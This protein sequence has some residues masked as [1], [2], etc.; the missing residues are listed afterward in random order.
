[1]VRDLANARVESLKILG[2]KQL[3]AEIKRKAEEETTRIEEACLKV[4]QEA[5]RKA[6]EARRKL[7][8]EEKLRQRSNPKGKS[9]KVFI[10]KM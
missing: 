4:E 8:E 1:M 10:G 7:A 6:E 3:E 9:R 2:L 5:R